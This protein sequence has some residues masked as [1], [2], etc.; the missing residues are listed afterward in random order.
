MVATGYCLKLLLRELKMGVN[1]DYSRNFAVGI[2][3]LKSMESAGGCKQNEQK[4]FFAF[5]F[6]FGFIKKILFF[7]QINC[8]N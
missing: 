2:L 5:Y 8:S 6:S 3:A 7:S 4:Y 1:T